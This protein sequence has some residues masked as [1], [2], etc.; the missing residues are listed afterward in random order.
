MLPA[1]ILAFADIGEFIDQPVKT[2]PAAWRYGWLSSVA[3]HV[4]A[5]ILVIDEA[6]AVGDMFSCRNVCVFPQVSGAWHLVFVSHDTA[7]VVT[8][9]LHALWLEQGT[10]A[11]VGSSQGGL[12]APLGNPL[13][14]S[15]GAT[16]SVAPLPR[17]PDAEIAPHAPVAGGSAAG[18]SNQTR[19]RNDIELFEFRREVN[20]YGTGMV[21]IKDV[22]FQ[23]E[24]GRILSWIV[25][26]N[27][28]PGREYTSELILTTL[29]LVFF[30]HDRLCQHLFGENTH[31]TY[32]TDPRPA[33]VN[34]YLIRVCTLPHASAAGWRLFRCS[35]R[36]GYA[37][38][39]CY[40][41]LVPRCSDFKSHASSASMLWVDGY[42][43]VDYRTEGCQHVGTASEIMPHDRFS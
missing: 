6:L 13:R 4:R 11:R 25:E 27:N 40:P 42:T 18:V 38:R 8:L 12:R 20:S 1:E 16:V 35:S 19:F 2:I 23:D 15:Q 17:Q 32:A 33:V 36:F 5:D 41:L 28:Y 9:R 39:P 34:Q 37:E 21:Q 3:A 29:S 10:G 14:E 43:N 26:V 22:H 31:L 24:Q 7:A 30:Y